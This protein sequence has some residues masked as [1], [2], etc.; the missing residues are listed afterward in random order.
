M[1]SVD[2]IFGFMHHKVCN[3][4]SE[5]LVKKAKLKLNLSKIVNKLM[6]MNQFY[7][8]FIFWAFSICNAQPSKNQNKMKIDIWSDV[9]CPFCYIGKQK[10]E[11][12]ILNSGL[13]KD[14]EVVW[15]SFQL[16]PDIP[17]GTS[18]NATDY[19]AKRKG[20]SKRDMEGIYAQLSQNGKAN[21][22]DFNFDKCL[23]FNTFDA[24]RL[25]HWSKTHNKSTDM[26]NALLKAYFSEGKDLSSASVLVQVCVDLGLDANE[27]SEVLKSQAFEKET[28]QDFLEARQ[29][30]IR[31]VPFFLFNRK[32][33]IS[34]AVEDGVFERTLKKAFEEYK[35]SIS[36]SG[37][38]T[39]G[40]VCEPNAACD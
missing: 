40:A 32:H 19:L 2:R 37:T 11:K 20:W 27:A 35:K 28:I 6:R 29:I 23:S 38:S 30:G 24:H 31:G 9:V 36:M 26:K 15:H 33:S 14:V 4:K 8:L 21:G 18:M 17:K 5:V 13:S 34:G 22:I 39:D 16:D 7:V 1:V 3:F 25:I 12:A 10:L